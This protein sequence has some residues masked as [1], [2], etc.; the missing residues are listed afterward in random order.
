MT[1]KEAVDLALRQNPDLMM[2]R[3]EEQKSALQVRVARDPFVP[4][5]VVG[6][7]L[8][9][10]SGFPMSIEGSAPS[11][12]QAQA[13]GTVFS[14]AK[15]YQIALARENARGSQLETVSKREDIALRA[16]NLFLDAERAA[17]SVDIAR[18]QVR[19]WK[20]LRWK[21]TYK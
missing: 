18:K 20:R 9:Y 6:S 12:F 15:S 4:K 8:A 16:A 2:S 3:L 11:I 19:A 17:R 21:L 5:V 7:G 13:I 10:S 1:L 14:K